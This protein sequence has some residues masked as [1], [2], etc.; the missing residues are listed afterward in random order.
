VPELAV[1]QPDAHGLG[2]ALVIAVGVDGAERGFAVHLH[3]EERVGG[4]LDPEF[5]LLPGEDVMRELVNLLAI[6]FAVNRA[7]GESEIGDAVPEQQRFAVEVDLERH[8]LA[9]PRF[10]NLGGQAE[11]GAVPRAAPLFAFADRPVVAVQ[12]ARM[13]DRLGGLPEFGPHRR[14]LEEQFVGQP[15]VKMAGAVQVKV[16]FSLQHVLGILIMITE[17]KI[18]PVV[19]SFKI[20][21]LH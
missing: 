3:A 10:G 14:G 13:G 15:F 20:P 12:P 17:W 6:V 21:L 2:D 7:A 16:E 8:R 1:E 4:R 11:P 9:R 18:Q 19:L 5:E